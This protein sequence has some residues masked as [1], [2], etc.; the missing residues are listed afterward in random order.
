VLNLFF[1]P[2]L[3]LMVEQARERMAGA[4]TRS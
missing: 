3:Y 4:G 1:I 2:A